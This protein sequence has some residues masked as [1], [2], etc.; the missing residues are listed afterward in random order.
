MGPSGCGKS[1][2][3]RMIAGL[4]SITDGEL[5]IDDILVNQIDA[6]D[7]DIAMV[8]QSY[9]L[10]PHMTAYENMAFGLKNRKVPKNEIKQKI[11]EVAKILDMEE[12]LQR[13]PKAMSGGQRQRV[14]LGR[15][16]VREPKVFLLDEPL[17]NLDAKLRTSMRSEIVKLHQKLETTFVYVTHD[18]M[19]AM[20]MGNKIVVM[21]NGVIQQV[22]TPKEIYFNPQ[23]IFVAGFIG[24]P[25]MN[26]I[27]GTYMDSGFYPIGSSKPFLPLT[28]DHIK[29]N[30]ETILGIRAEHFTLTEKGRWSGTIRFIE[31]LGNEL[32]ITV[33]TSDWN[34]QLLINTSYTEN[35]Q[36]G[37][38]VRFE[39]EHKQ[40]FLFD[41]TTEKRLQ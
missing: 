41:F 23:N 39:I 8:F 34:I 36:I 9:A 20:T 26:F 30:T 40:A 38:V 16:M 14:A 1:T 17:S 15:A 11:T 32:H 12:L 21:K 13:K 24:T 27:E 19:E 22:G 28:Y 31:N 25:Q 7:R 37:D 33:E 4:E 10:F 18:Q 6:S 2:L 3:L 35:L 5:L 29:D